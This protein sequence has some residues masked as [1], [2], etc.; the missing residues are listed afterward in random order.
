MGAVGV[1]QFSLS[2][3]ATSD[4]SPRRRDGAKVPEAKALSSRDVISGANQSY[5]QVRLS[6][7]PMNSAPMLG[8]RKHI[9]AIQDIHSH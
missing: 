2:F 4:R 7:A 5:Q 8:T 1:H 3:D 9:P 6:L